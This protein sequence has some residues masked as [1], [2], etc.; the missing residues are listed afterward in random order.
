MASDYSIITCY[1]NPCGYVTKAAN[2]QKFVSGL[3]EASATLIVVELALKDSEFDLPRASKMLRVR[4]V[5]AIW[6]KERLLSLALKLLPDSCTKVFWI[7]CDVLFENPRWL[8]LGCVALNKFPVIQPYSRVVRLPRGQTKYVSEGEEWDSFG[9]LSG[10]HPML[11]RGGDFAG[12]G[13]SGFAWAARRDLLEEIGF[14]DTCLTGVGD[15]LMAHGFCGDW[16]SPCI[17]N[18]IGLGSRYHAHF[19]QWAERAYG[20]VRGQIGYVPG[21]LLHLWHGNYADR[22]YD[23]RNEQFQRFAFDPGRDIKLDDNGIWR[24]ASDK[25]AMHEWVRRFFASRNEDGALS[26]DELSSM[27]ERMS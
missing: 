1:F 5:D 14:Y 11:V 17:E 9:V 2:Y 7:D 15:H 10:Q 6:Q 8:E 12:H 21:R 13:H 18:V 20:H 4:S 26:D 23:L 19:A 27:H 24:W 25:A 16:W 3:G 22:R